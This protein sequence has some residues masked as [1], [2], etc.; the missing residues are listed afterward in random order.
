MK[1][2]T[3][4]SARKALFRRG[5]QQGF[6]TLDEIDAALPPETLSPSD[7]WLLFYSLQAAEVEIRKGNRV[8]ARAEA[9]DPEGASVKTH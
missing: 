6:L 3:T 8:F 2:G 4:H 7:R 9:M 1:R 5:I